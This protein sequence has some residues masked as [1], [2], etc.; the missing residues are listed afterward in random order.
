MQR[1]VSLLFLLSF[2]SPAAAQIFQGSP[3][4]N[5]LYWKNR[6]PDADYWQQ[7]VHYTIQARLD[8][9]AH[10]IDGIQTLVYT[11]NSPDTLPVIYFHLFQNAFVKGSYLHQLERWKGQKP[12][13]G[14]HEAAGEGTIVTDLQVDG[15][16]ARMAL[17]NTVMQVKL[18]L[19]LLPGRSIHV[20]LNFKTWY[21]D[22][23]STRRRMK[24]YDAWGW[25]HYN[26]CQW[27]PKL[28]VY[29][30][31]FGWDTYQ[32]MNK[33][34][35]GDFG[36]YD[37]SL[38]FPSNY[39]VEATGVLE[40]RQEVLPDTLR[41]KLDMKNFAHKK[42]NE[43][44]SV[45]TPYRK[46]E[47]KIWRYHAEGV[48]D[49]A[50]TADPSYRIATTYWNGI[51]CVGIAQ[52]PHASGWQNSA[53]YVAKII[54]TFSEDIG[55]YGYPKMV[56]ADAA[57][58]MEYPMLTLDGGSDPGYHGLLVHEIGHNWF[59]GM[60]GSN[61]TYRAALDEGFTQFLT[62]WGLRKIDGDTMLSGPAKPR[63]TQRWEEPLN[64]MDRNV[65][66]AYTLDAATKNEL[67]LNT[68]SN[69]FHDALGHEGGYRGVYYK[70]AS[71][72]Y[73][74][75][76]V[77][78]DSLFQAAFSHYFMQW[79]FAHPY[80]ED[81]R[82]SIIRFTH[83]DLNWFFDEWL[84]T[85]KTINY[86]ILGARNQGKGLWAI[87]FRRRGLSQMPLDFTVTAR[88]GS[89]Q[90]YTLP[91]T[92]F[93]KAGTMPLPKWWGW[94]KIQPIY[95][96]QVQIPSGLKQVQ[97]DTSFRLAD[98][99]WPDNYFRPGRFNDG[100]TLWR[101]DAGLSRPFDR[102]HYR[103]WWRPDLWWNALDGMKAGLHLEGDY[104]GL[105]RKINGSLWWNTHL[106]QEESYWRKTGERLYKNY[107]PFSFS[108]NLTT[109]LL[110]RTPR[111]SGELSLRDLD[112]LQYLKAGLRYKTGNYSDVSFYLLGMRRR[113]AADL[114][115]L[116]APQEWSST[117]HRQN[118]SL[119]LGY[120]ARYSYRGYNGTI[121][122][123]LRSPFL[124]GSSS[125]AFDYSFAELTA[126]NSKN[127]GKLILHTRLY[128]R[129]G[130]GNNLPY[131]SL[132]FTA[133]AN[134][135]ALME[136]KYTRSRGVVP[137]DAN[138]QGYN[139]YEP[140]HFQQGGGLNLRGYSGYFM[141]DRR[142]AEELI[143]YKARSGA[144]LN[145]ELDLDGMIPFTPR[146]SRNW[147]HVDA[148]LF[149]DA[150]VYELSRYLPGDFS[151]IAP[152]DRWSD[153]HLDAGPGLAF[154]IKRF[155]PFAQ[156]HPL[157]LRVDVPLFLN[158][159]AYNNPQYFALRYVLG[160]NR[161]F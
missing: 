151:I 117:E 116:L 57:D 146:F 42:W 84:E 17:D 56:A 77:L 104:L 65:L 132:L 85:T 24:M 100:S 102:R 125:E 1:I 83:V 97:I 108:I 37:V 120:A 71:M 49:F 74:L 61:E 114:D 147:L 18:P 54:R 53:D 124:T 144:A 156:A 75:Q 16:A 92:W 6:K 90:S 78:G 81:F 89:R 14:A 26:G 148:Y 12:R 152:T 141:P 31:K 22:G 5:P 157:T 96:A 3:T 138:W 52:E 93:N 73:N 41:Q 35:Y 28:C 128:G 40:N 98:T 21:D 44:P 48:H 122:L 154:T 27:F 126:T 20:S 159:P 39:V 29:D 143:G 91:N 50:F 15:Q 36:T 129:Y 136:D 45:I 69:D 109:I 8:E 87:R 118:S 153:L 55:P 33:E 137:N 95:T 86:S 94:S 113:D 51:E 7:D 63:W 140:T 112:G 115:Y 66:N 127:I 155:G 59:Y 103:A 149:A 80:F 101:F 4:G 23:G 11:N 123:N 150:G 62:S 30:R 38:D 13:L 88:D 47:R 25:K 72:L 107:R 46:G 158:R 106:L 70:T 10:R 82:A 161:T 99:Y 64:V 58:G 79:R 111:L 135:E 105:F 134:Q 119:N 139:R 160:I 121:S 76:Y 32:H 19:P 34:F 2:F 68:Q 131:E 142:H 145:A 133:G 67:P 130:T 43:P 110:P 60:V 9:E